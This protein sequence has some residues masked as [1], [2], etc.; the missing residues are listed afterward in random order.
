[1]AT[2]EATN[3][4]MSIVNQAGAKLAGI[5]IAVEKGFQY[6]GK[7]LREKGIDLYSLAIVEKMSED[8]IQFRK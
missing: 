1:M 7:E 3:G 4:M 2:G 8:G 5:A 6:G